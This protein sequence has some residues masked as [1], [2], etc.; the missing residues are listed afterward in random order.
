MLRKIVKMNLSAVKRLQ[1]GDFN[2]P[3][4]KL[5]ELNWNIDFFQLWDSGTEMLNI[6]N[7]HLSDP[8]G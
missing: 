5:K 7:M 3:L 2:I 6:K 4:N 1:E 8:A